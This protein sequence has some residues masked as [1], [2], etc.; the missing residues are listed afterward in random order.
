MANYT[1]FMHTPSLEGKLKPITCKAC[2]DDGHF[3]GTCEKCLKNQAYNREYLETHTFV[4]DTEFRNYHTD[5][6]TDFK[7]LPL[8]LPNEHPYLYYGLELE[9]EFEDYLGTD[10]YDDYDEEYSYNGNRAEILEKCNEIFPA[11]VYEYD[12]S[13]AEGRAVEFI[14]RP[15]SYGFITAPTTIEMFKNLFDYLKSVGALVKQPEGNGMHIHLSKKFFDRGNG[16][17]NGDQAYRDFDWLFQ[18][19]QPQVELL[20]GRKYTFYCQSK[21]SRIKEDIENTIRR[22]GAKGKI[23]L[24]VENKNACVPVGD[25]HSAI[26]LSGPT[27]EARVFRSTID[28]KQVYANI[29]LVRN[30]AHAVRDGHIKG[31]SLN[32]LLH[33]KDNLFLDEHMQKVRMTSAKNKEVLE[34]ESVN[35]D[36]I[37]LDIEVA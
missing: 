13:L 12:G 8:R 3:I 18:K 9:I 1:N 15:M 29:E 24:S 19:F 35:D 20:G 11:I 4:Y 28:Y 14:W 36:K 30:F 17:I 6:H 27:I 5:Q 21:T 22:G 10:D 37:D 7:S 23:K 31:V 34:L 2:R 32:E 26:T 33:T 25:H 16:V